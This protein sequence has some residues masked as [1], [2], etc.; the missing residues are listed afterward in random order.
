VKAPDAA[1]AAAADDDDVWL[2][3]RLSNHR[4][5]LRA[6]TFRRYHFCC[7]HGFRPSNSD[8]QTDFA[9]S[10]QLRVPERNSQIYYSQLPITTKTNKKIQK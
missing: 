5:K 9:A 1:A 2:A 6:F 3:A 7:K 8:R 10:K 4:P